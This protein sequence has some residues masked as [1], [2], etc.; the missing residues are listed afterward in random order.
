MHPYCILMFAFSV[1]LLIYA[2]I[3]RGGDI[4]MIPRHQHAKVKDPK[5]YTRQFSAVTAIC[6]AA[7]LASGI[8]GL[9]V[10]PDTN[11]IPAIAVL[12]VGLVVCIIVSVKLLKKRNIID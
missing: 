8:M 6:A 1:A 12:I 4:R 9:I 2:A 3:L 11:A 10:D 7:P 5:E